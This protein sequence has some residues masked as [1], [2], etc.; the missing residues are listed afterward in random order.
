MAFGSYAD[1]AKLEKLATLGGGEFSAAVRLSL[2]II[3]VR[4]LMVLGSKYIILF[5]YTLSP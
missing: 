2:F 4:I 1:V 5:S 3:N